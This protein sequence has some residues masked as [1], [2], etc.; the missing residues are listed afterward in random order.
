MKL[1]LNNSSYINRNVY[2]WEDS[3]AAG[4]PANLIPL[5][6]F[7]LRE[8]RR[9]DAMKQHVDKATPFC[10]LQLPQPKQ[11]DLPPSLP[12]TQRMRKQGIRN[13]TD[14]R[15]LRSADADVFGEGFS[16][17]SSARS[18]LASSVLSYYRQKKVK[19]AFRIGPPR[20]NFRQSL[21]ASS[22][23]SSVRSSSPDASPRTDRTD[24]ST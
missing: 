15:H 11:V 22:F 19:D 20:I 6:Q 16:D 21:S 5:N 2:D 7:K 14:F 24:H 3:I 8:F 18:S 12:V 4:I 23:P 17:L 13:W 9:M 10:G 1:I